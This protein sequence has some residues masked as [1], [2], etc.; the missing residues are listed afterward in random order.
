MASVDLPDRVPI[1]WA[2]LIERLCFL[3]PPVI[4]VGAVGI[5]EELDPGVPG[6]GRAL[7]LFGTFGYTVLTV[8]L[9]VTTYVDARRLRS[10]KGWHPSPVL[11]PVFAFFVPPLA[12]VVY[13]ARRHRHYGTPGGWS[14]WWLVVA[15]STLVTLL[16]LA[17][18]IVGFILAIPGLIVTAV[19]LGGVVAVGVFPVALHQDAAYVCASGTG[20]R[21]NPGVYL[22]LAFASLFVPFMLPVLGAYYLVRRQRSVGLEGPDVP[23]VSS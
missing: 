14:G 17:A 6:L 20:W 13:L 23:A 15:A 1:D 16:G 10:S 11:N 12:G 7:V 22:G 3:Y 18:V 5:V 8:G 2:R 21:P 19:G 4:G 9:M